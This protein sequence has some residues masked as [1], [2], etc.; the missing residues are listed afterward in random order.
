MCAYMFMWMCVRGYV[1]VCSGMFGCVC[2]CICAYVVRVGECTLTIGMN[3]WEVRTLYG[4]PIGKEENVRCCPAEAAG[5]DEDEDE[6]KAEAGTEEASVEDASLEDG[7]TSPAEDGAR[8]ATPDAMG[9][10]ARR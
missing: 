6:A 2:V 1:W 4:S 8:T 10:V 3:I 9:V 7:K 5:E